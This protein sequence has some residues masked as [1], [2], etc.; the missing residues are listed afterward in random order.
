MSLRSFDAFGDHVK[1]R[2]AGSCRSA[3]VS[4]PG[5]IT[6]LIGAMALAS[7]CASADLP[8]P[9]GLRGTS[10][11]VAWE[12]VAIRTQLRPNGR[13]IRWSYTLLLRETGGQRIRFDA[14][15]TRAASRSA[16]RIELLGG[17]HVD[18]VDLQIEA[19]SETRLNLSYG[20]VYTAGTNPD[21]GEVPGG[22]EGVTVLYRLRGTDAS[23]QALAVDVAVLLDPGMARTVPPERRPIEPASPPSP[24]ATVAA[25]PR[26][27]ITPEASVPQAEATR[28]APPAGIFWAAARECE[29]R[30]PTVR[31]VE[32]DLQGRLRIESQSIADQEAFSACF[33]ARARETMSGR[34][35]ASSGDPVRTSVTIDDVEGSWVIARVVVNESRAAQLVL[36][37]GAAMT[38]LKPA[39]LERL[40]LSVS[41]D[42]PRIMM[43]T[44]TGEQV[45]VPLIRMEALRVGELTVRDLYAGVYDVLPQASHL[46]GLLGADFLGHFR[47]SVDRSARRLTLETGR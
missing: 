34:I 8:S 26:S 47:V 12:V 33:Q 29:R 39:L 45:L 19:R 5:A 6:I 15:E 22:R 27:A 37:T 40:G 20:I 44:A 7:A 38:V 17:V 41:A 36:D 32:V 16:G 31:T 9:E 13:E 11:P 35:L 24:P 25:R 46:D 3:S 10:G 30:F 2:R 1:R 43:A 28:E 42:A 4:R 21:L 14:L 18:K 23:G